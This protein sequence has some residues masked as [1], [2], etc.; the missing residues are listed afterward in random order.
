MTLFCVFAMRKPQS[1]FEDRGIGLAGS[2]IAAGV[3]T[4]PGAGD[5]HPPPRKCVGAMDSGRVACAL[6][7]CALYISRD[8]AAAPHSVETIMTN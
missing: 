4:R 6:S 1:V 7:A 2:I 8:S 3:E 5:C